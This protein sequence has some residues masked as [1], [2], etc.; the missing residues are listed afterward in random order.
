MTK[1]EVVRYLEGANGKQIHLGLEVMAELMKALDW[2]DQG[3]KIIHI[4][5][6]NG[7]GSVSAMISS[8]L[9]Y[10]G[11][12]VGRYNSPYFK[13]PNECIRI[14]DQLI[15][16]ET[17]IEYM[18]QVEPILKVLE[19]QNKMPSGFEIL[20]A[21]AFIYFRDK[22][23]DFV[24]LEV[25]LG[26][27]L[28]ATNVIRQSDLSI[29][30]RIAMD[31]QNF[32]G[33]SLELIARE[34]AGIIKDKGVVLTPIQNAE[35][36]RVIESQCQLKKAQFN[37]MIEEDIQLIHVTEDM[38]KFTYHQE[39][40]TLGISGKYQ[41]YNASLAIRAVEILKAQYGLEIHKIHIRE[42]LKQ[43][44]WA[45]RFE[46]VKTNPLCFI[47]GAHNVD[48]IKALTETLEALPKRKTI[49]IIGILGDKEVDEM[50][51][52]IVPYI[53]CFIVTRPLSPRAMDPK[54]LAEKIKRYTE[55]VYIEEEIED[56]LRMALKLATGVFEKV[57]ILGF[58]SLYMIG[59]LRELILKRERLK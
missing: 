57:Q 3:L 47:D 45:G 55:Q 56:A 50:L 54:M 32:L 52:I 38:V 18:E 7:K 40:Y 13:E 58:G 28:D 10:A 9:K 36:M 53:E 46:K 35:V 41:A 30:T 42:G 16:D 48:G 59:I 24:V 51:R 8:I 1:A 15:S 33:D 23:V 49:A 44:R 31:H 20:T 14:D 37:V 43:V 26:G 25:G 2:P 34:K 12:K 29:I 5:G 21:L 19:Q 17:L 11:Y 4:A 22:E 39:V 6:T 27:R